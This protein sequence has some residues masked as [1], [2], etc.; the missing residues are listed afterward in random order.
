MEN[1][2][3]RQKIKVD[4]DIVKCKL[5][6]NNWMNKF[7]MSFFISLYIIYLMQRKYNESIKETIYQTCD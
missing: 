5:K 6:C 7:V 4:V 3:E 1:V 2:Y